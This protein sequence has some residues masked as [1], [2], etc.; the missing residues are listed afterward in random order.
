MR[1]E[2]RKLS[3]AEVESRP[4]RGLPKDASVARI[5]VSEHIRSASFGHRTT[6]L[7][8]VEGG[9]PKEF[10]VE[11]ERSTNHASRLF[12]PFKL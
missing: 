12:G 9:A 6:L 5:D 10:W 11:Y 3:S 8:R 1:A 4:A 2:F 7:V